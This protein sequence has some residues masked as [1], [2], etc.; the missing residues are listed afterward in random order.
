[1]N[2]TG[3]PSLAPELETARLR[4]RRFVA[5][6]ADWAWELDCDPEVM[7][8]INGG[9]PRLRD[10]FDQ[11]SLPRLLQSYAPGP[12]F[13]FWSATLRTSGR[14]IGWFHLRPEKEEPYEMDLGYRL[15][16]DVWGQGLATEGSR[17]LLQRAFTQW[18]VPRVI[19]HTLTVNTASRRVMEKCG[20]RL[21]REFVFPE[22]WLPGLS[23]EKRRAVRY[24]VDAAEY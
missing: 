19:A 14:W 15:R 23:D 6:D 13:G 2:P 1:M 18:N 7:R 21:E 12:Q 24:G 17:E 8:F 9:I 3:P 22:S 5:E 16:R 20:M 10:E 11:V 4:L